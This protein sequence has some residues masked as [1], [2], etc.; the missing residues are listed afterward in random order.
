MEII[1]FV[2]LWLNVFPAKKGVSQVYSPRE[3]LVRWKL[4]YALHC[5]VLPGTYC[6]VHKKP[7]LSNSM[8]PRTH[9]CIACGLTGNLQGSVKFYCLATGR[10]I[11]RQNWTE[12]PMPDNIIKKVNK[13]GLS[14]HQGRE[15]RF[16]N[17]SGAP[18]EWTD[19]VPEDDPEFQGLLKEEALFH[20]GNVSR[21][22]SGMQRGKL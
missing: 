18:Y 3:L 5:K 14:E 8:T 13:I 15:F 21:S 6:E 19:S 20:E 10:I 4:D 17:R 12:L 11:K 9:P 7:S 1:Y 16:P 22:A 2:V